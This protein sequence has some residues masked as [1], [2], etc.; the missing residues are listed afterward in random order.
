MSSGDLIGDFSDFDAIKAGLV[1]I[2]RIPTPPP[3]PP[4]RAVSPLTISYPSAVS[5]TPSTSALSP[6][7][8]KQSQGALIKVAEEKGSKKKHPIVLDV[9]PPSATKMVP[10]TKLK[11]NLQSMS[12]YKKKRLLM[13]VM[14]P[15]KEKQRFKIL[16]PLE[17]GMGS[18][19]STS[20]A[21][22]AP[23]VPKRRGRPPG[24]KKL[25]MMAA[26]ASTP[27]LSMVQMEKPP[28]DFSSSAE[29]TAVVD[30]LA[31]IGGSLDVSTATSSSVEDLVT[32]VIEETRNTIK[33]KEKASE[34]FADSVL[35]VISAQADTSF[36]ESQPTRNE[37]SIQPLA[38]AGSLSSILPQQGPMVVI[39][40]LNLEQL[41]S[42][43]STSAAPP[44]GVPGEPS[45]AEKLKSILSRTR[46]LVNKDIIKQRLKEKSARKE[47]EE[48]K[49][50]D[51][52]E[53]TY[54]PIAKRQ[55]ESAAAPAPATVQPPASVSAAT[56]VTVVVPPTQPAASTQAPSAAVSVPA[57]TP[58]PT[59]TPTPVS[60]A[61]PSAK[62]P[63]RPP[64]IPPTSLK[65]TTPSAKV[66][67]EKP[68][69]NRPSKADLAKKAELFPPLFQPEHITKTIIASSDNRKVAPLVI[70]TKAKPT[71]EPSAPVTTAAS[72]HPES[73]KKESTKLIIKLP[74]HPPSASTSANAGTMDEKERKKKHHQEKEKEK[75]KEKHEKKE[76]ERPP[77]AVPPLTV[78]KEKKEPKPDLG[79]ATSTKAVEPGDSNGV[80][81]ASSPPKGLKLK[82]NM[83]SKVITPTAE[84]DSKG[85]EKKS[86]EPGSKT[87]SP[88]R[89]STMP[90]GVNF[91]DFGRNAALSPPPKSPSA[92]SNAPS[93][94]GGMGASGYES[95]PPRTP[96]PGSSVPPSPIYV[97]TQSGE[98]KIV[99]EEVISPPAKKQV[100]QEENVNGNLRE[101]A[102]LREFRNWSWEEGLD[103]MQLIEGQKAVGFPLGNAGIVSKVR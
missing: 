12:A 61:E 93:I 34:H 67:L 29:N 21:D 103:V 78:K 22:G 8:I 85:K 52:V 50:R 60:S 47:A 77:P 17:P 45:K 33:A 23:V 88:Q 59:P 74:H 19:P 27:V 13:P 48:K 99:K 1:R 49:I 62:P 75:H 56:S 15:K 24:S 89:A 10:H 86:K 40:K 36:G 83:K 92:H 55:E 54:P 28:M 16:P 81:A 57:P 9:R 84:K 76:K 73:G 95:P 3:P 30:V 11:I 82:I 39:E 96:S 100:S 44:V 68:L 14:A 94:G 58:A 90:S 4:P 25:A 41:D 91:E 37:E 97:N 87:V 51:V 46:L 18:R 69:V 6:T 35:S 79:L 64:G 102:G 43:P 2:V 101:R 98:D 5:P 31:S 66:K 72:S 53:K 71:S 26:A 63:R 70:S 7:L 20:G 38:G 80:S 65:V 42:R 32:S